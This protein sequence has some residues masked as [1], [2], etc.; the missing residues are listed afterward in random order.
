MRRFVRLF[1]SNNTIYTALK[2]TKSHEWIKFDPANKTMRIGISEYAQSQL[3]EII[4]V[5][6]A[7][8]GKHIAEGGSVG[9][10]ESVKVV[11]DLYTPVEGTIKAVNTAAEADPSIINNKALET[12]IVELS[13]NA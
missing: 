8:V 12:W 1:S 2:F 5:E 7:K 10:L 4:H 11:A 6:F 9:I 13:C 3:G